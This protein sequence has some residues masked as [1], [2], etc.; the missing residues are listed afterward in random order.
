MIFKHRTRKDAGEEESH[1]LLPDF[2][3]LHLPIGFGSN[4]AE[5]DSLTGDVGDDDN[6]DLHDHQA[7]D[8]GEVAAVEQQEVCQVSELVLAG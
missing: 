4:I 2:D 6:E 5:D 7:G 1:G 3:D 8:K